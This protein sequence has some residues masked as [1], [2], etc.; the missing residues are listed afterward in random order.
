MKKL[1]L[2]IAII[3]GIT[4]GTSAQEG[5]LFGR[6]PQRGVNNY[7]YT[8]GNSFETRD[9]LMLPGSHGENGDQSGG[10][11]APLGSG[12]AVLIGFGAAYAMSKRRKE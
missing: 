10:Q 5:G 7:D 3:L 2:T 12:I 4:I 1:V 11:P 6:G 8:M 9:G